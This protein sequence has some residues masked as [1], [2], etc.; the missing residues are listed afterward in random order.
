MFTIVC[1]PFKGLP[2]PP[3]ALAYATLDGAGTALIGYVKG[4]ELTDTAAAA[5]RLAIG[6]RVVTRFS[7][8]PRGIATDYWFELEDAA[9]P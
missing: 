1:E 3:Y 2:E 4:L 5:S 7:E 9:T 6:R 8:A